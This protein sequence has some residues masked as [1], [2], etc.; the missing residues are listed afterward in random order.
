MMTKCSTDAWQTIYDLSLGMLS[1]SKTVDEMR[2]L[3]PKIV[4]RD[5]RTIRMGGGRQNHKTAWIVSMLRQHPNAIVVPVDKAMRNH[6]ITTY[7][8]LFDEGERLINR[9][10]TVRDLES[11]D[12]QKLES[13]LRHITHV[14]IDDA[15]FNR[16]V[17]DRLME[18]VSEGLSSKTVIVRMG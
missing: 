10:F 3:N 18:L 4:L 12:G 2:D 7:Q 17:D 14:L 6:F 8:H 16:R 15:S 13:I 11:L 9:V 5:C 1:D